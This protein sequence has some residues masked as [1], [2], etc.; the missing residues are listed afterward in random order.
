MDAGD[1]EIGL[2]DKLR[3]QV[4]LVL[5]RRGFASDGGSFALTTGVLDTEPIQQGTSASVVS[6]TINAFAMG[7]NTP[8]LRGLEPV[9]AARAALAHAKSVAVARTGRVYRVV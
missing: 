2:R 9:S 5:M 1:Y 4:G 8:S 7:A 6:G 3:R